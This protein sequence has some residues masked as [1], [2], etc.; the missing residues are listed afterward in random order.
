MQDKEILKL[1]IKTYNSFFNILFSAF[2]ILATIFIIYFGAQEVVNQNLSIG[3]LS[4]SK[5]S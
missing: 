2:P 1:N 5:Y 3:G 4:R